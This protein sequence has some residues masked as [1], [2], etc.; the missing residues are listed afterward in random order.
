[1]SLQCYFHCR[2][3]LVLALFLAG[4]LPFPLY[5]EE[6]ATSDNGKNKAPQYELS[7]TFSSEP[8]DALKGYLNQ[9]ISELNDQPLPDGA[10]ANYGYY[11]FKE[12]RDA[13]R[14]VLR[15]KGY[16]GAEISGSYD[17]VKREASYL[18]TP[19]AQYRF[20]E[21]ALTLHPQEADITVPERSRLDAKAGEP[22][23]ARRV[24]RDERLLSKT[25]AQENCLFSQEVSHRAVIDHLRQRVDIT[26]HITAG[27]PA[28]IGEIDFTGHDTVAESYLRKRSGLTPGTCFQRSTLNTAKVALQRSGVVAQAKLTLPDSPDAD[29]RVPVTFA[30]EEAAHRTIRAGASFSTDIGPGVNAGWEHR[31]FFG[32]GEQLASNLSLSPIEQRLVTDFT[33]PYFLRDDQSLNLSAVLRREDNEAFNVTGLTIGGNIQ[34]TLPGQ[35]LASVGGSYGFERV[36]DQN[37]EEDVA[38]LT[39]PLSLSK[40]NRNDSLNPTDGWRLRLDTAP[41]WLTT[42]ATTSFIRNEINGSYYYALDTLGQP[43]IAMR[44]GV[45]TILGASRDD[46]PATERFYVGGG[47]SLRGYE[48]QLAGP[49]DANNNPIGGRS[50]IELSTELRLRF[51]DTYGAV[52][53]VDAGNTFTSEY[54]DFDS[55]L[56]VGAGLGFRYFTSFGPVRADIAIP[57]D[58]RGGVDDDFQLYFSIGQAF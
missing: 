33:K 44:S 3:L 8:T 49:L 35:W 41:A 28:T 16:Y 5:A 43:V 9:R 17:N 14:R 58:K 48:F 13:L 20:G 21:I 39:V 26:Y 23:L 25:I 19:G 18:I 27:P 11:R 24:L 38:Q 31:N 57:L 12:D 36:G 55:G 22:A 30:I 53:F 46:I 2:V 40:D 29:G 10:G 42:E 37:S 4:A 45:G 1:M 51:T 7:I 15:A 47:S 54:P 52:A 34:R 32:H 50:Y 56:L 6:P